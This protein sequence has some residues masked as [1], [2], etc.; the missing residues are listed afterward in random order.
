MAF[1]LRF[2]AVLVPSN[3]NVLIQETYMQLEVLACMNTK[4]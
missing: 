3:A 4:S 2:V 1:F